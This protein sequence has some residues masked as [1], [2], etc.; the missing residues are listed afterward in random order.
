MVVIT[1][2]R[3]SSWL[4]NAVWDAVF[5]I[6]DC[7]G[8]ASLGGIAGLCGVNLKVARLKDQDIQHLTSQGHTL[9]LEGEFRITHKPYRGEVAIQ[10][11]P[12]HAVYRIT[13]QS[14]SDTFTGVNW[15][16]GGQIS[17]TLDK[18][19]HTVTVTEAGQPTHTLPVVVREADRGEHHVRDHD[20]DSH[21][22]IIAEA[23]D[24]RLRA[25]I[26]LEHGKVHGEAGISDGP[27]FHAEY[28]MTG[29]KA[30]GLYYVH[31]DHL[32]TPRVVSD[33]LTGTVVWRW[34]GEPFGATAANEDPD[35]DGLE[36]TF[37]LRF[38]GQY[39]D[40]ETGLNYNYFRDY[41]PALGRYVESDPIG[42]L[43]GLNP[44]IYVDNN[45]LGGIDPSGEIILPP[46]WRKTAAAVCVYLHICTHSGGP[47]DPPPPPPL[48]AK[49][50]PIK[51]R[52]NPTDNLKYV[53]PLL[54]II[55]IPVFA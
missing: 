20:A 32:G 18:P 11:H 35:G 47:K 48:P 38:P 51:K 12:R 13:G 5:C 2:T 23:K 28:R 27:R 10:V 53:I 16:T 22:A 9:R 7:I 24:Y 8:T 31:T 1:I 14:S 43:G 54:F 52:R 44:Y 36:F 49:T 40:T 55:G 21:L 19:R 33:S 34:D 41:D 6:P 37:N 42:L 29:K 50:C 45:P 4:N 26:E 39:Y 25:E 3:N 15:R 46:N 17:L 30:G